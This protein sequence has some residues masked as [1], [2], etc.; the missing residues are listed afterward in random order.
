MCS[1]EEAWGR[2]Y[3]S[4]YS[5]ELPQPQ[6]SL[7]DGYIMKNNKLPSDSSKHM[8]KIPKP[9]ADNAPM[10]LQSNK[11]IPYYLE[12]MHDNY[13]ILNNP[14]HLTNN[15]NSVQN[16]HNTQ[17]NN[18]DIMEYQKNQQEII[19]ML[20]EIMDKLDNMEDGRRNINDIVLYILVGMLISFIIYLI[21]NKLL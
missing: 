13:N 5:A 9:M 6:N 15:N 8:G 7:N 2:D 21:L 11:N 16:T 20:N 12:N 19:E 17:N 10:A 18:N 3:E 1:L 4:K 14:S